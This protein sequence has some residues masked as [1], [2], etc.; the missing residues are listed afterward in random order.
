MDLLC[1]YLN[2]L[3]DANYAKRPSEFR[4]IATL[5]LQ[6]R[7]SLAKVLREVQAFDDLAL[8]QTLQNIR[9]GHLTHKDLANAGRLYFKDHPDF[10]CSRARKVVKQQRFETCKQL[11]KKSKWHCTSIQV[12][13]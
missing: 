10:C 7:F 13:L 1:T 9:G 11:K 5:Y 6:K 3:E 2:S 8:Q 12:H 4:R